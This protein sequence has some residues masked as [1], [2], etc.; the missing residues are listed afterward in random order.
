M[1]IFKNID[2]DFL[3]PIG[4]SCQTRY[5]IERFL[6]K[7]Y[8]LKQPA[9]Y[10]DWLGLGG[11]RGVGVILDRNFEINPEEFIVKSVY[12]KTLFAPIHKPSGFRFQHDFKLTS[13]VKKDKSQVEIYMHEN[14][15][16][17][18]E[19]YT[20]LGNRVRK[21]LESDKNIGL[22]YRGRIKSQDMNFLC[23]VLEKFN[24]NYRVINILSAK[25]EHNFIDHDRILNIPLE[26]KEK[27]DWRGCSLG[28]DRVLKKTKN[29]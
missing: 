8:S 3:L 13:A 28:W 20:H 15:S 9:C 2:F 29:K 11:I 17:F 6:R 22:V 19:K 12:S 24:C 27:K 4:S 25:Y 16:A 10:F 26:E 23:T 14:M 18:L 7:E 1:A 21:I 5:Q